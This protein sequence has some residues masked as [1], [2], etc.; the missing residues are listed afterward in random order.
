MGGM[1]DVQALETDPTVLREQGNAA[2]KTGAWEEALVAYTKAL[3]LAPEEQERA[4]VLKNRA[5]VHLKQEQYN[6]V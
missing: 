4:T 1:G 3:D 5:A 6:K 2:F